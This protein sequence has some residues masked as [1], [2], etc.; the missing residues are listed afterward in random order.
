MNVDA[1]VWPHSYSL[2]QWLSGS[3]AKAFR[4]T[5]RDLEDAGYVVIRR[6]LLCDA[7]RVIVGRNEMVA[8]IGV[9][10]AGYSVGGHAADSLRH[11]EARLAARLREQP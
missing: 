1:H 10:R 6:V 2:G 9:C 4:P 7:N 5:L 11:V 8:L 3:T